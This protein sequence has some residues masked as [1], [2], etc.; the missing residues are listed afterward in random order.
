MFRETGIVGAI[1]QSIRR[2][3]G[4]LMTSVLHTLDAAETS[5]SLSGDARQLLLKREMPGL[6]ALRGIAVLSVVLYHG[7]YWNPGARGGE[8]AA[9]ERLSHFFAFGWLGVNLFFVLS[10]FLIT[11]ILLDTRGRKNYGKNFY[12]RRVLRILPLYV[13]TL[14]W[15][16]RVV[17]ITRGYVSLCLLNMA[18]LSSYFPV[19]GSVYRPFWSL[20]VEEQF[21]LAWPWLVRRLTLRWLGYVCMAMLV[22]CPVLRFLSQM[23]R[24]PLG[25]THMMTWLIADNLAIGGL[26]AVF[27]RS[28]YATFRN[29]RGLTVGLLG[30]GVVLFGIDVS[31]HLLHRATPAGAAFQPVP[32]DVLFAGLVMVALLWGDGPRVLWWTAPLRFLGYISYGMYMFH[33]FLFDLYDRLLERPGFA[34]PGVMTLQA[35]ATRFVI[36]FMACVLVCFLSRR[37]FEE[38][39]LSL[40]GKLA[41][42]RA[43]QG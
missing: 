18:N 35:G 10:G 1:F 11:G 17:H 29:A 34:H 13:V 7:L 25:D 2:L 38:Y 28:R 41:P 30:S 37:Y 5:Q 26:I 15:L 39:F 33:L 43:R 6:D 12:L 24:P 31:M 27:L 21:Y 32:L 14:V 8:S 4:H 22:V 3:F 20:A 40:K 16:S 23:R 36:V 9:L 42:G 19:G